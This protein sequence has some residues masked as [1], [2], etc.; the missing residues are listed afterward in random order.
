[1]HRKA[2]PPPTLLLDLSEVLIAGLR[3]VESR[4]AQ[5]LTLPEDEILRRLAGE[6]LRRLCRGEIS[7]D[8]YLD[9]VWDLLERGVSSAELK[10]LLRR[11]FRHEVPGMPDLVRRL[12]G[13]LDLVLVSDHGREWAAYIERVHPFLALFEERVYSFE[14][15][16]LKDEPGAFDEILHRIGRTA[17]VCLFIDDSSRNVAAAEAEGLR[18]V[19][20]EGRKELERHLRETGIRIAAT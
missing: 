15:G 1:L 12:E 14:T 19:R 4:L 3:G 7:E 9:R 5:R 2:S 13:H 6:P 18:A 17:D 8:V 11:N 20:F 16:L 10:G